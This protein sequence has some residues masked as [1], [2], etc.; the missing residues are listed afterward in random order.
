V[1]SAAAISVSAAAAELRRR[2]LIANGVMP[3]STAHMLPHKPHPKQLEFLRLTD[4]EALYGGAAGGGKSD[5]Q[6]MCAA[7]YVHVPRYAALIIRKTYKDLAL[8]GA[9]MDR[10]LQWWRNRHGIKWND[11]DRRLTFPSNATITFGYLESE[12]DKDRYQGAEIQYLG[13]DEATQFPESRVRYLT[14]RLR[15][16]AGSDVPIRARF[17]ANP[18]GIGHDWVRRQFVEAGAPGAF[19]AALAKD[20]PSLDLAEYMTTLDRLDPVTRQQL[21][22]GIWVRDGGGLVYGQFSE[23]RN[24]MAANKMPTLDHYLLALDFGVKDQNAL[25]VLGWRDHDPC[26]YIVKA[27]RLTGLVADVAREVTALDR[28]FHFVKIV[29][30]VGGMG[31]LFQMELRKR[32]RLPIEPAEKTNKWGYISLLNSD[33]AAGRVKISADGACKDLVDEWLE[34]PTNA[35]GTKE[36][37]GFNNH[38]ADA[39]LYGWRACNA[40]NEQPKEER[41]VKGSPEDIAAMDME[42]ER[43]ACRNEEEESSEWM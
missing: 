37:E 19:I 42:L 39:T 26:I 5:A 22:D 2:W 35:E 23:D 8:P 43:L 30:D 16:L 14:S 40:Y 4:R 32:F 38:A 3:A 10:G 29:G 1:S 11:E 6:L 17:S 12:N 27:Y 13:V 15:R 31:K 36:A 9:I 34:L 21:R 20:N 28:E 41:P 24:Y 18:G 33:L 7:Q 25:S